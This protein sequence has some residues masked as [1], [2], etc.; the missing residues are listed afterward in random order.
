MQASINALI[1]KL[2]TNPT[3]S[4]LIKIAMDINKSTA[5][6]ET[7]Q[8]PQLYD[9]FITQ[10]IRI[11]TER[12]S[13]NHQIFKDTQI[14]FLLQKF[15]KLPHAILTPTQI[16]SL[17]LYS[18]EK[19]T[20]VL[21][22]YAKAGKTF[23][24]L[25]TNMIFNSITDQKFKSYNLSYIRNFINKHTN[26]FEISPPIL[27]IA[28]TH[29]FNVFIQA[30]INN[31]IQFP[32]QCLYN[33]IPHDDINIFKALLLAGCHIDAQTLILACTHNTSSIID[34]IL[35]NKFEPT[36]AAF[37]AIFPTPKTSPV[38]PMKS[39]RRYM[40][41]QD[42]NIQT[43]RSKI[44]DIFIAY[45]YKLTSDDVIYATQ[46]KTL[47]NNF[48]NLSITL[49]DTF[50]NTCKQYSFF[51]FEE[52]KLKPTIEYL[53]FACS[54][55]SNLAT[56]KKIISLGITPTITCLRLACAHKSNLQTIKYLIEKCNLKP[57]IECVK[58]ISIAYNNL[59]IVYVIGQYAPHIDAKPTDTT[60]IAAS[61]A[62]PTDTFETPLV[63][64]TTNP[65]PI[66]TTHPDLIPKKRAKKIIVKPM[67]TPIHRTH[68]LITFSTDD[69]MDPPKHEITK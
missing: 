8:S 10:F 69:E 58:E 45:G 6:S 59:A 25:Q 19:A 37:K 40:Q 53:E 50:V 68:D 64:A 9:A 27:L 13:Y 31:K 57:D 16:K 63:D 65:T 30:Q 36:Q 15:F 17:L 43:T 61:V 14:T 1:I 7:I 2:N 35:S 34:L 4:D 42:E 41:K 51:P 44:I 21:D 49:P 54:Q 48:T 29:N 20:I 22:I 55:P 3:K 67:T 33:I 12:K 46:H 26:T 66:L 47:I 56:I 32:Q 38:Q 28:C 60:P 24:F 18:P 5:N 39:R 11:G 23:N 52:Y 62:P